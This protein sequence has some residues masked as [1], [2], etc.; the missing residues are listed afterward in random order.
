VEL[1]NEVNMDERIKK[2]NRKQLVGAPNMLSYVLD[3]K[4]PT[5]PKKQYQSGG[6]RLA[7]HIPKS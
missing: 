3:L 4:V 7:K 1:C 2:P 6:G 5:V